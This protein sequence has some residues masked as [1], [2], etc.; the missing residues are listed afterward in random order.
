MKYRQI[1]LNLTLLFS[2]NALFRFLVSL[3]LPYN[4]VVRYLNAV[5]IPCNIIRYISWLQTRPLTMCHR[6]WYCYYSVQFSS[7]RREICPL[8]CPT[9]PATVCQIIIERMRNT[10]TH[11]VA[12]RGVALYTLTPHIHDIVWITLLNTR[13][14]GSKSAVTP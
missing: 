3:C 5:N 13:S 4:Y 14:A 2:F 11:T 12:W 8:R 9:T 10:H 7:G 6:Y 1:N